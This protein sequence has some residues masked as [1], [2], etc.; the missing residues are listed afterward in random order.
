MTLQFPP[1]AYVAV[2]KAEAQDYA[3][4]EQFLFELSEAARAFV[5]QQSVQFAQL[6]LVYDP[7]RPGLARMNRMERGYVMMQCAHRGSLQL[8]LRVSVA[9]IRNHPLQSKIRWVL[10]VDPHGL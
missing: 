4:V 7:V 6:P 3:L 8:L 2:F 9:W 5:M 10:D 1:A